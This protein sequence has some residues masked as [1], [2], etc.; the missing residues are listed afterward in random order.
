M[1]FTNVKGMASG[2]SKSNF[3]REL[4][5]KEK[6]SKFKSLRERTLIER[7][8]ELPQNENEADLDYMKRYIKWKQNGKY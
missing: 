4:E 7:R 2:T 8:K 6:V 1:K 5:R 3:E